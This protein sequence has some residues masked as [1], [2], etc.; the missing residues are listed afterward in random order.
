[1]NAPFGLTGIHGVVDAPKCGQV[2]LFEY[3]KS[4][5]EKAQEN[6]DHPTVDVDR[7]EKAMRCDLRNGYR[8]VS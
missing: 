1:M 6:P 3:A 4:E 7:Q 2:S 8:P 5:V